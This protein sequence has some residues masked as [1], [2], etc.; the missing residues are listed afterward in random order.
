MDEV[1]TLRLL[2]EVL[3]QGRLTYRL[4]KV[5]IDSGHD[6]IAQYVSCGNHDY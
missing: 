4:A 5:F 3:C 1:V 6:D 2:R